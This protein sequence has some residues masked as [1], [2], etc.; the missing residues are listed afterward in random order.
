MAGNTSDGAKDKSWDYPMANMKLGCLPSVAN[1]T[2]G[3][4]D[5]IVSSFPPHSA[6]VKFKFFHKFCRLN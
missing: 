4:C 2:S 5:D 6:I 3:D 1:L